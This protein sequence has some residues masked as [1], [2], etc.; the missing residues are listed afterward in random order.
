MF[1]KRRDGSTHQNGQLRLE[2]LSTY[3]AQYKSTE[4][5]TCPM[6]HLFEVGS[7]GY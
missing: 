2:G 3:G 4:S 5:R 7:M 6:F 1:V